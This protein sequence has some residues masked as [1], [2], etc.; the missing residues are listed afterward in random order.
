MQRI[1]QLWI[2]LS[3]PR[4]VPQWLFILLILAA[5]VATP[6]ELV[7]AWEF[8]FPTMPAVLDYLHDRLVRRTAVALAI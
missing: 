7:L 8:L 6:F 2:Y 5:V 4:A 1:A 3:S